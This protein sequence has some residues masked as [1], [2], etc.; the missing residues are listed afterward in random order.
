MK[1]AGHLTSAPKVGS[2]FFFSCRSGTPEPL[3]SEPPG[4][5]RLAL[6]SFSNFLLLRRELT[7]LTGLPGVLVGLLVGLDCAMASRQSS[8]GPT[9][10]ERKPSLS[11]PSAV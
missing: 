5:L 7:N 10:L 9:D 3:P 8:A 11:S 4:I 1:F 2:S 6:F